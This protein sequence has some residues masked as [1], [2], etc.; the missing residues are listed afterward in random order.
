MGSAT[1]CVRASHQTSQNPACPS[2]YVRRRHHQ[3]VGSGA[4]L[5]EPQDLV[6]VALDAG[7]RLL[8]QVVVARGE[9]GHVRDQMV[10]Q[11]AGERLDFH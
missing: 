7:S 10:G 4:E 11:A 1:R 9:L 2:R 5:E 8:A 6:D 3:R